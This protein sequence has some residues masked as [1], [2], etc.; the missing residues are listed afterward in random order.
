MGAMENSKGK[1]IES[2][3][4][5]QEMLYIHLTKNTLITLDC[6]NVRMFEDGGGVRKSGVSPQGICRTL[7][8]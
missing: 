1:Q 6:K 5:R 8:V 4:R 2:A 3:Y 7:K